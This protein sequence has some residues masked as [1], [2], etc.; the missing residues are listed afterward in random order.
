MTGL[1][2]DP[3]RGERERM[4]ESQIEAR[5]I[6]DRRLLEAMRSVP[7]ENFVEPA[8]LPNAFHDGPLPIGHG[9]TISQPYIV[10]YMTELLELTSTDRVLEIGTGCGYQTAILAELAAAVYT[11]EIVA[12][13]AKKAEERL[14]EAGYSNIHFRAGDGSIGWPEEAPYDAIMVTAAPESAP[15]A[16]VEQL[17][18]GGRMVVPVGLYEQYIE[19]IVK[20]GGATRRESLIGVRFVPMTGKVMRGD[21]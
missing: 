14:R 8:D 5:G 17:A 11:I 19:R 7:R 6:R 18:E 1:R 12:A 15:A 16:L 3:R 2:R 20:R 13:L 4:V 9:Q 10:A 21:E